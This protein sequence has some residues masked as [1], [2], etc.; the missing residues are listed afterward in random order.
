MLAIAIVSSCKKSNSSGTT[1]KPPCNFCIL[2]ANPWNLNNETILTDSANYTYP[3]DKISNI[4]W[5]SFVF[6][7]DLTYTD[8]LSNT[9]TYVY[10]DSTS[11]TNAS[12]TLTPGNGGFNF[13]FTVPSISQDSLL[14]ELPKLQVHPLT[15]MS[16]GAVA[17]DHI[18][19]AGLHDDFGVD[20]SRVQWIQPVF[21]YKK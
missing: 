16:D 9:G 14:L 13:K 19:L 15:D 20:T 4:D 2:T 11:N 12:L 7:S 10:Y 21:T 5:A 8:H 6:K 18:F 3:S 1:P 17:E